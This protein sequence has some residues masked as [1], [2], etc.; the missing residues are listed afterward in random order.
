MRLGK[1]TVAAGLMIGAALA[2]SPG[3]P[4]VDRDGL[5]IIAYVFPRDRVLDPAD[6]AAER[7]TH[8]NYAFALV[9]DGQMVEGSPRDR[10]NFKVLTA[11]RRQH[12][13]LQVLVSVGGWTGSGGFSDTALT[14]EGR[15]RFVASAM[16]FVRRHDLDGLDVDWEYPGLPGDGNTHRPQDGASYTAL[17]ADLRAG[18]DAEGAPRGRRYLLTLAAG[19]FPD[20]LAQTEMGKVQ[21]SVDFVNLMT[22][23][24][25]EAGADPLAGHH[26]NLYTHPSDPNRL[27]ADRAVRDFLAAGVPPSK[28]VLG[29]PFYGRAWGEVGRTN[30][31]L[32]Q[33]GKPLAERIDTSYTALAAVAGQKGWKRAWDRVS[34]APFLWNPERR[35]FISYEDP[36]SLRLKCRYIRDH[37]L[38]GVMFW[39]YFA[40]RTG[41][42][43]GV[44]C[45]EL[46]RCRGGT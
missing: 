2:R 34:Q 4:A 27:S 42:L 25:R 12:P 39:E 13:Q 18:L 41:T 20:F 29:V 19:A 17:M 46:H 45:A 7:L 26:A 8:V 6:I 44:L 28:L 38:G 10:E 36:R 40:D 31:G 14:A 37:R 23:D 1:V 3:A 5:V 33:A 22:Y 11:L 24:F 35:V 15:R 30:K 9:R 16:E 32:Y 21:V 43:L